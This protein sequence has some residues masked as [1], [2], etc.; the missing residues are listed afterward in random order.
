MPPR[1]FLAESKNFFAGETPRQIGDV[2]VIR[3]L[4][5]IE[6]G[7]GQLQGVHHV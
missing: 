1:H 5:I 7:P 6:F 2:R 4:V 3:T